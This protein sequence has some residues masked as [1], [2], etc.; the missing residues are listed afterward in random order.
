MPEKRVRAPE[1]RPVSSLTPKRSAGVYS[2]PPDRAL[3][4]S[5]PAR[6]QADR[7]AVV[8]LGVDTDCDPVVFDVA[9]ALVEARLRGCVDR[10]GVVQI[11]SHAQ[12]GQQRVSVRDFDAVKRRSPDVLVA[13]FAA[14]GQPAGAHVRLYPADA[15][16]RERTLVAFGIARLNADVRPRLH[17]RIDTLLHGV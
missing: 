3:P 6:F 9:A 14:H 2:K 16:C 13:Q 1:P 11:V 10:A 4:R 12:T 15:A 7:G 17:E 5:P 8:H